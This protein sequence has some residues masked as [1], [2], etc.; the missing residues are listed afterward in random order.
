[1]SPVRVT[2]TAIDEKYCP[3]F[4]HAIE[5]VGRRWTGAVILV[6][7]SGPARYC[8]IRTAIPHLS[9]RLLAERLRELEIEGIVTRESCSELQVSH[10]YVLTPKG[11]DLAPVIDALATWSTRRFD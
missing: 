2:S 6:L 8:E 7:M 10:R 4:Q 3:H 11:S 5:L 9:D 1:M